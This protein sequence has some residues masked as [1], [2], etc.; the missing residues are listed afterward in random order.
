M[1]RCLA[2][3]VVLLACGSTAW[4]TV[5]Q[6]GPGRQFTTIQQGVNAAANGDTVEIDPATYTGLVYACAS[7]SKTNLTLRGVGATRPVL[8]ANGGS[9]N[10]KA[11]FVISGTDTTIENL[12]FKNCK[13][14]NHNGAGIRQEGAGLTVRNCYFHDN[15]DGVLVNETAGNVL[16]EY[17]EFNHNGYGDGQSHNMYINACTS[18]TLRY[19]YS[20]DTVEGHEVKTR[21]LT[22][23]ILYNLL[24]SENGTA[25]KELQLA[26]GGT[27]Y[28]VGNVIQQGPMSHSP[29]I[30]A[31]GG[32]G[33][34][35]DPYL[36]LVNNTIIN[37]QAGP[38]TF[39][40]MNNSTNEAVLQNNIMQRYGWETVVGGAFAYQV[41]LTTNWI[42]TNAGLVNISN[43]DYHL[44]SA[45]TEAIDLGTAPGTGY[46]SYSLVPLYEYV[47]PCNKVDR[48]TSGAIDIGAYE[49]VVN[50]APTVDAGSDQ[51]IT[52]PG[53]ANLSGTA[54]DDGLPNPPGAMT[55]TWSRLSGPSIVIFGNNHALSTT[56]S[57]LMGG[58]Y[59]LR[60]QAS[61]SVLSST[62]TLTITVNLAPTVDAGVDQV[63]YEGQL[64][65]LHATGSDPDTDPLAYAW[66]QI[67][68]LTVILNG[69][70]AA[71][72]SFT[73][74]AV[75]TVSQAS[76]TFQVTVND[77]K[78]GTANDSVNVRVYLAGDANHNDI[79]DVSDLLAVA[80]AWGTSQADP[81]YNPSCDFN[82]DG[83]VDAADLLMLSNNWGKRL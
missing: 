72:A 38:A 43:H 22:N 19:C 56:A 52:L 21:A 47:H 42:T 73:A 14:A 5:I 27:C 51:T 41:V 30:V 60:L 44:T 45:S 81:M 76:M 70:D 83:L 1:R 34:N 16:I 18:F 64:V 80:A 29:V 69:A 54:S 77:G 71:D 74:P 53:T 66:T 17:S 36:Y 12:E 67:A 10:G 63:A 24:S 68:G 49:Y 28:V 26:Q 9:L 25:S 6:V 46:G 15:E 7:I 31:Y 40:E 78:G 23:Y 48:P 65:Q 8:D 58:T 13:C 35:P 3:S 2:F 39:L 33:I 62:D 59:V 75:S 50:Q 61:D 20:H 11:I 55:Y 82:N 57:F 32:E 79:V 4:G 37:L